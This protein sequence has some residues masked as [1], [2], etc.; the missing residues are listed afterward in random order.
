M[1]AA[2]AVQCHPCMMTLHVEGLGCWHCRATSTRWHSSRRCWPSRRV[3]MQSGS[4]GR[5]RTRSSRTR[6]TSSLS[7]GRC[8]ATV[9][10]G[11]RIPTPAHAA[12]CLCCPLANVWQCSA[13]QAAVVDAVATLPDHAAVPWQQRY[14]GY[15]LVVW[16]QRERIE[17]GD[18]EG[19]RCSRVHHDDR[20]SC[21]RTVTAQR[22]SLPSPQVTS[23]NRRQST[24]HADMS[25]QASTAA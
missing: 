23:C 3:Q 10:A 20:A 18:L 25:R 12:G 16:G 2:A 7:T 6:P 19:G 22:A 4:G 13:C 1:P 24:M 17:Q 11:T 8:I 14:E 21:L 5:M 15:D 9:V